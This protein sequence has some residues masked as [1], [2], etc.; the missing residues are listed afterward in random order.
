MA[1]LYPHV[2]LSHLI[3]QDPVCASNLLLA[4]LSLQTSLH[5]VQVAPVPS[6]AP[7]KGKETDAVSKLRRG[8]WVPAL[9]GVRRR[10]VA[11]SG[12]PGKKA[13][14]SVHS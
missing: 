4:S 9:K 14:K 6:P 3:S 1:R 7:A 13:D 2:Q 8:A 5:Q 10:A 11:S 12:E